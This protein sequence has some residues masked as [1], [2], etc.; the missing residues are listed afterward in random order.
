[1]LRRME[2]LDDRERITVL[3]STLCGL[4]GEILAYRET[5]ARLGMCGEW[6][7]KLEL[8]AIAKLGGSF[9]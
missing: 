8:G 1:M 3:V 6:V 9:V 5:G 2:I 7:R 4:H